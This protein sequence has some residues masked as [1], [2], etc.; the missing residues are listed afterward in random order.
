MAETTAEL[1]SKCQGLSGPS[2]LLPDGGLHLQCI[3][4]K[5]LEQ[6]VLALNLSCH[7]PTLTHINMEFPLLLTPNLRC[8]EKVKTETESY[9]AAA[10]S[11]KN[12]F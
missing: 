8:G 11:I 3:W 1:A 4:G 9:N 6:D 2:Y 7:P 10:K 5:Y 12:K